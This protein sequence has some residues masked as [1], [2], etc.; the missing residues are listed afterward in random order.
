MIGKFAIGYY[1]MEKDKSIEQIQ[2]NI[3][4]NDLQGWHREI[5][6][7][8]CMRMFENDLKGLGPEGLAQTV[9]V[10]FKDSSIEYFCFFN[11]NNTADNNYFFKARDKKTFERLQKFVQSNIYHDII[12]GRLGVRGT[13]EFECR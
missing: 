12:T 13:I 11:H 8:E 7:E 5:S 1:A 3:Y 2:E 6:D 9:S 10:K 4:Y